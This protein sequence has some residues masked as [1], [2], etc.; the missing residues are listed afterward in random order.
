[1][2]VLCQKANI[3]SDRRFLLLALTLFGTVILLNVLIASKIQIVL[4]VESL[5][6]HL[7]SLVVLNQLLL[8]HIRCARS[9][10]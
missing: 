5:P 8:W 6:Y 1:M 10:E 2:I 9:R 7:S 4:L 3:S